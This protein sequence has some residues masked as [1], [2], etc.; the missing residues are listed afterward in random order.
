MA[1]AQMSTWHDVTW[2]HS[3]LQKSKRPHP[4]TQVLSQI[5]EGGEG[6]RGQMPHICLGVPP[7]P[8]LTLIDK[9][10]YEL[11]QDSIYMSL[12]LHQTSYRKGNGNLHMKE[13]GKHLLERVNYTQQ[14]Q[15]VL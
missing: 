8:G 12:T 9:F 14:W 5:P 13:K 15:M 11:Q 10:I 2:S 3:S 1:S 7:P 4:G 6:N